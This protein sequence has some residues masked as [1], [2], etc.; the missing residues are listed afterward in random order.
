MN[1]HQKAFL[2]ELGALLDKYHVDMVCIEVSSK[3]NSEIVFASNGE[4]IRITGFESRTFHDI[5]TECKN[6]KLED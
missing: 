3:P 5:S 4:K 1:E 2:E 6:M